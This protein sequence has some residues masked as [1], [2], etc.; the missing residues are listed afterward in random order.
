MQRNSLFYIFLPIS[1]DFREL[2]CNNKLIYCYE[3]SCVGTSILFCN[4]ERYELVISLN[5][6]VNKV[7]RSSINC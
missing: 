4:C 7:D 6:S 2:I 3:K 5:T 1:P